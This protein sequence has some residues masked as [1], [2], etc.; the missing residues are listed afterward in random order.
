MDFLTYDNLTHALGFI[1][2]GIGGLAFLFKSDKKMKVTYA[3]AESTFSI[4]F[5]M[6]GAMT[7]S[8]MT[9]LVGIRSLCSLSLKLKGLYLP[10]MGLHLIFG[11]AKAE[12]PADL[13]ALIGSLI[14]THAFFKL[15][16]T[17]LRIWLIVVCLLWLAHNIIKLSYGGI[18]LECL[19]ISANCIYLLKF[20]KI[21]E[22]DL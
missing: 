21:K 13:L 4:H 6:L 1:G 19:Y 2:C 17:K 8:M 14:A 16:G 11:G 18:I 3:L 7:A 5:F 20:Y 9:A 10:F 15:T 22:A 12:A